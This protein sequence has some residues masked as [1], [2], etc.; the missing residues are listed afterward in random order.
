M[1]RLKATRRIVGKIGGCALG[2]KRVYIP[3]LAQVFD[4]R[5]A[6]YVAETQKTALA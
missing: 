6:V 4:L 5:I 1:Y 3:L 2:F